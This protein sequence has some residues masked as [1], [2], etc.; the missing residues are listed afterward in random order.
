MLPNSH[1][2][3]DRLDEFE[4]Q[5]DQADE[6]RD[7][8][9]PDPVAELVDGKELAEIAADA[10]PAEALELEEREADEGQPD[11]DV[12]I[13]SR[14]AQLVELADGRNES[15]PVAEQDEDEERG[16]ERDIRPGGITAE[17]DAEVLE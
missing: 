17:A 11:G 6:H 9:R 4:H 5:L 10:V 7:G 8:A 1:R 16:K 14:G 2:Q 13:R 3:R 15:A 12:E